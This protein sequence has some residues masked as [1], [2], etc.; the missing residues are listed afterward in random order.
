MA[1]EEV[2]VTVNGVVALAG[3]GMNPQNVT[4]SEKAI[5]ISKRIALVALIAT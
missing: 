1:V 5:T 2:A 4:I 3:D